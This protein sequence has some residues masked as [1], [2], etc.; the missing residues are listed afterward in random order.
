[1]GA[2]GVS[3]N[4]SMFFSLGDIDMDTLDEIV[5]I[6]EGDLFVKNIN[7]SVVNGFPIEG[8]F[9]G[10]AL[11]ANINY[12]F[13]KNINFLSFSTSSLFPPPMK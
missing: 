12:V 5:S 1:M 4:E 11:I 9:Q 3:N 10:V 8:D 13:S 2:T 7:G 6:V